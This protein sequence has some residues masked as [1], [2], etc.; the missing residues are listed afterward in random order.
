MEKSSAVFSLKNKSLKNDECPRE[1]TS[2][3]TSH[4]RGQS[5]GFDKMVDRYGAVLSIVV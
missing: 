5:A 3:S 1:R 4:I 2:L